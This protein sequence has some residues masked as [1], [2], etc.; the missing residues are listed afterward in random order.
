MAND[1][2]A[3]MAKICKG[4][5][6]YSLSTC[7]DLLFHVQEHRFTIPQIIGA[8]DSLNLKFLGFDLKDQSTMK[9]FKNKHPE[10]SD[11]LS[12][13]LWHELEQQYPD[14][15]ANMYQFWCIK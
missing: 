14:T 4:P 13:A 10:K 9:R 15:F 1:G 5:D 12:L 7:R 3:D 11:I 2:N 8:L 6:F